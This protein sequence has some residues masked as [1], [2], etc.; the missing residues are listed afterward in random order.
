MSGKESGGVAYAVI[1]LLLV[2]VFLFFTRSYIFAW[3]KK[4]G[5][6]TEAFGP[7]VFL[8]GIVVAIIAV[9]GAFFWLALKD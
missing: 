2:G 8:V 1:L 3:L 9:I 4:P 5:G 6:L 7:V